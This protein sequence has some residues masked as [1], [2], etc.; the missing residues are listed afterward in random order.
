MN[1]PQTLEYLFSRLPMFQRIGAPAYKA[2][3]SNT[4]TLCALLNN[5]ERDFPS[6]HI[7]GTNGKGSVANMTASILQEAGYRTGLFTSP[8]L[9]DFR[10][11]IRV[12]GEMI[13]QRYVVDFVAKHKVDFEPVGASFFEYVFA[14]GMSY[15]SDEQVDVAVVETGMG[16]R[17]DSTNVVAPVVCAITNIGFDHTE[18]LGNTL[19]AIALEKAGII[20]P[21]IPVVI[22]ETQSE[23]VN[24]F[25]EKAQQLKSP[26]TFADRHYCAHI[27]P[28]QAPPKG[29]MF[30]QLDID[31]NGNRLLSRINIP[32]Q[33]KYQE[34]NIATV[35]EI[36]A[37]LKHKG[38]Q[39]NTQHI[40]DGLEK[41]L[42]N[43]GFCGR[44]QVLSH[45]PL[46]VADAAHNES[47][48]SEVVA[49]IKT[50]PYRK[51]HVVLGMVS[52][53]DISK[54]LSMLPK[55]AD[56]YFC[57]ANIPRG[58]AADILMREAEKF[59]LKGITYP[60]VETAL[61]AAQQNA[62]PEDMIFVG[63]SCFTV[64]EVV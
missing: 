38:Y 62:S 2:D 49:Q 50:V 4:L 63:G 37:V 43:T 41:V 6:L 30:D 20:K 57:K 29:G 34:K 19:K 14:L 55:E 25:T 5:P 64:A 26:I 58:L 52:D 18:F 17:L 15:F 46:T 40:A 39:I 1:Y 10:E 12:N 31:E 28:P 13:S 44:W 32:L 9:K 16:G 45:H 3:L 8:H 11:R 23:T 60:S 54:M 42:I 24:V 53:K 33:G 48:M 22:G 59:D 51:L 21:E 27:K 47:G 36:I 35:M 7:A 56:Y 61:K